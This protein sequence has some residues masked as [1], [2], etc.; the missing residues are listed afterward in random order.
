MTIKEALLNLFSSTNFENYNDEELKE[1]LK[2]VTFEK[3][4][5]YQEYHRNQISKFS[6][7]V[8]IKKLILLRIFADELWKEVGESKYSQ[9]K[10]F[11]RRINVIGK[12]YHRMLICLDENICMVEKGYGIT[13]LSNMRLMLECLAL[14]K[15]IWKK[16][17]DEA[18]R[19]QD[20]AHAQKLKMKGINPNK[21][22][23]D[24]YRRDFYKANGWISDAKIKTIGQMVNLLDWKD[25]YKKMYNHSS[26]FVHA[27]PESIET[28]F[29][30]NHKLEQNDYAY[31]PLGFEHQIELNVY[32]IQDFTKLI[33]EN[34]VE[35]ENVKLNLSLLN[36]IVTWI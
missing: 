7:L 4:T 1:L 35:K 26:E 29:E 33:I 25:E 23:K 5:P 22:F 20:F 18:I 17:E 36:A 24:K 14:S 32:L 19:F 15:Y 12:A 34:F 9:K 6:D 28:V 8:G 16:G 30:L 27:S 2:S 11:E 31:F 21:I 10:E 3:L 13:M